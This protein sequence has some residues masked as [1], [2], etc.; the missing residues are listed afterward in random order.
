MCQLFPVLS[1]RKEW[2]KSDGLKHH[3]KKV[4]QSSSNTTTMKKTKLKTVCSL[5]AL[6]AVFVTAL[7]LTGCGGGDPPPRADSTTSTSTNGASG[8]WAPASLDGKTFN[9]RI[10]TTTTT[11]VIVFTGGS[12]SYAENGTHLD[13]GSFTYTK[14]S[15]TT[16]VLTLADGTTLQLT[17]TGPKSGDYLISKSSETGTFTSN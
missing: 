1:F 11:W 17:Y 15:S 12:Y 3:P 6:L 4:K 5:F 9:G 8:D 2:E 14:T 10:G 16:A 13:S 7:A